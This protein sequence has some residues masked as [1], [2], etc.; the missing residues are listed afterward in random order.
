VKARAP[1]QLLF[2]TA[3]L[4]AGLTLFYFVHEDLPRAVRAPTSLLLAP[5]AVIDGL[6]YA[7]G[8]AGIYGRP[9]PVLLVNLVFGLATCS[10]IR[11][12]KGRWERRRARRRAHA[13]DLP[14]DR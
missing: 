1:L 7:L 10:V 8:V 9:L 2:C 3:T 6:C 12:V 4:G 14:G 13:G 5:V 11:G